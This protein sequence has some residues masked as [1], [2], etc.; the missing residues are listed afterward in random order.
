MNKIEIIDDWECG[1]LAPWQ[2]TRHVIHN[3]ICYTFYIR[4]RHGVTTFNIYYGKQPDIH[5]LGN[6]YVYE[7]GEEL[8]EKAMELGMERLNDNSNSL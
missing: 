1:G 4:E 6:S 3:D 7:K 5:W 2:C 8:F